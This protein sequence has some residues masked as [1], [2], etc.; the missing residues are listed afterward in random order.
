MPIY[1][2]KCTSCEKVQEQIVPM[3]TQTVECSC[4]AQAKKTMNSFL[5]AAHG[6]PNGHNAVRV[7]KK[8][9]ADNVASGE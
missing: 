8:A 2:F 7:T 3:G 9:K 6:L 5:F 4:G 1:E